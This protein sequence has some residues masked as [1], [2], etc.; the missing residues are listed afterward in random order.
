[1][2]LPPQSPPVERRGVWYRLRDK[3]KEV[4]PQ[5]NKYE[6]DFNDVNTIGKGLRCV[7]EKN[8]SCERGK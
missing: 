1:M 6:L 2:F 8:I 4:E 5:C 7:T 3:T